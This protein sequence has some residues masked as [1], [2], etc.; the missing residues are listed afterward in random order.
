MIIR[1]EETVPDTPKAPGAIQVKH[2][3][4]IKLITIISILLLVALGAITA[5]VSVMVSR[6]VQVTAEDNN[7]TI[8]KRSAA[9]AEIMLGMVRSN[10]LVLL[11]TLNAV[12]SGASVFRQAAGFF[13]EHNH[14]IAAIVVAP[15][16]DASSSAAASPVLA[17]G[18]VNDVFLQSHEIEPSR[19]GAFVEAHK[20]EIR[21][22]RA[23]E[24]V[25]LNAAPDF[26]VPLLAL[27]Y[28]WPGSGTWQAVVIF[29]SLESL[30]QTFGAGA[31]TT[32]MINGEG[33]VLVHADGE[34]TLAG[35]NVGGQAFIRSLRESPEN[36]LQTLYTGEDGTQVFGAFTRLSMAN[37]AVVT[38]V[39][40]DVVFE[41]VAATTRRNIYL[42]GAV[43]L[44]AVLFIWF[45]SKSI[46]TPLRK[47]TAA[48]GQI[49]EGNFEVGLESKSRDEIGALTESFARMSS[50]LI[51][52][53]RFTNREIAVRAMRGEIKR[54][55]TL[56]FATI[57]FS[58]IRDFTRISENFTNVFKEDA[59][60]RIV[61][62]LNE[63][64]NQMVGCIEKTG[65][66]VV[67]KF[68]GDAVMA[69]WGTAYTAGSPRADALACVKAA[70]LMRLELAKLNRSRLDNDPKNPLIR[71]GCGINSGLVTV[72]QIG[73]EKRMEYTV[74]GDP[75]NLASRSETLNKPLHTDI[76]ITENTWK[77]VAEDLITE[78]MPSVSMKGKEKPVRM[79]AVVNLRAKAGEA[80]EAPASLAELRNILDLEA[81][82][83]GTVNTDIE[84][85]K[86][87]IEG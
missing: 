79:F 5:L 46:S 65:G 4:G 39:G 61:E 31:N 64:F 26:G 25:L 19:I 86:Y 47:L 32:F 59:S 1:E 23:E 87:K 15:D 3:I 34:L 71:I 51:T 76:L 28:P 82:D 14:D 54:G 37:A 74:V 58:D 68:I 77:L 80:Q 42:T 36:S 75:V 57:F 70:L 41:G 60:N 12:G 44:T 81:V 83:L 69:H 9:E 55:G 85:K 73:S 35:V 21:R 11:D 29:F 67:D 18:L 20:E 17:G 6:D 27:F 84:E 45:F 2:P 66:G 30:A 62:W 43:L 8:N 33:D 53:G 24:T 72:G 52:F 48:A 56:K 40:Y 22:A 7:F 78:E 49:Q 50:A 13:F 10:V 63:Y 16:P 38:T